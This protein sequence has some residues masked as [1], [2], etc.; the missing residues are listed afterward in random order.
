MSKVAFFIVIQLCYNELLPLSHQKWSKIENLDNLAFEKSQKILS[1]MPKLF[2]DFK[3]SNLLMFLPFIFT[4]EQFAH[5]P[6]NIFSSKLMTSKS[7]IF[8]LCLDTVIR[9]N[10]S[11]LTL[12]KIGQKNPK[13]FL[14][15]CIN[16]FHYI[17]RLRKRFYL[18]MEPMLNLLKSNLV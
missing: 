2:R 8:K 9:T 3:N 17:F 6:Q 1:K 12:K 10:Q 5:K 13:L 16:Q 15:Y 4:F 7:H 18:R 11:E 14:A